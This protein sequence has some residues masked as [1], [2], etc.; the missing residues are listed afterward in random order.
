MFSI[1]FKSALIP[2]YMTYIIEE[3][4]YVQTPHY[5]RYFDVITSKHIFI[6]FSQNNESEYKVWLQHLFCR[7]QL[8]YYLVFVMM[9]SR[10]SF[11]SVCNS[12]TFEKK[13]NIYSWYVIALFFS[14]QNARR[15]RWVKYICLF[16]L[17]SCARSV[18]YT[19]VVRIRNK[20]T[21]EYWLFS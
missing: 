12:L 10:N 21:N 15:C 14:K 6:R 8:N 18:T 2:S 11:K 16:L 19:H 7:G 3:M 17:F 13:D 5:S 9:T 4:L 20:G 1:S